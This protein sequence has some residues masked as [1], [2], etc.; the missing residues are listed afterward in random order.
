MSTLLLEQFWPSIFDI[1]LYKNIS[2]PHRL[3]ID[4]EYFLDQEKYFYLI[5]FHLN[6]A[7]FIAATAGL[8]IGT[9]F[10]AYFQYICGMFMIARYVNKYK[11]ISKFYKQKY[12]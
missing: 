12:T 10:I 4:M 11:I 7:I 2:R 1:I 9:I 3:Q 5:L 6:I 8:A